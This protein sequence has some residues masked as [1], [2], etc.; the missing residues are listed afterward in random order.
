MAKVIE[1]MNGV[2]KINAAK[3]IMEVSNA[4]VRIVREMYDNRL[5]VELY[6]D[7]L[8]EKLIAFKRM[9]NKYNFDVHSALSH[10]F[11]DE[12]DFAVE[13]TLS[14]KYVNKES[15]EVENA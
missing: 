9:Q 4:I 5:D 3:K 10:E 8:Y 15:E 1:K 11:I 7:E 12:F 6:V 14:G 2:E 13:C